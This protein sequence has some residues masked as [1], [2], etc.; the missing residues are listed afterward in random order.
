MTKEGPT[1][2]GK[3]GGKGA[4]HH[5]VGPKARHL[6]GK[7]KAKEAGDVMEHG[8]IWTTRALST[9]R[10]HSLQPF[11]PT[12]GMTS[13]QNS[14]LIELFVN[15]SIFS[16]SLFSIGGSTFNSKF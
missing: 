2:E 12:V 8:E 1:P 6:K 14:L 7:G 16:P 9:K 15:S 5:V 4:R 11:Q 3:G 10:L 13:Q